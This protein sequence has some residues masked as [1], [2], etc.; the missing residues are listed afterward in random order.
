MR[1]AMILIL[2]LISSVGCRVSPSSR[3]RVVFSEEGR[4][5]DL[6]CRRPPGFDN[7]G[8]LQ[9]SGRPCL[10][11]LRTNRTVLD[12]ERD[13]DRAVLHLH[14]TARG[15]SGRYVCF[16]K[17]SCTDR[18]TVVERVLVLRRVHIS[19]ETSGILCRS[20]FPPRVPIVLLLNGMFYRRGETDDPTSSIFFPFLSGD[21][22][23]RYAYTCAVEI[24]SCLAPS[25]V[26]VVIATESPDGHE[27]TVCV[28]RRE[29]GVV[30]KSQ[31]TLRLQSCADELTTEV[32]IFLERNDVCGRIPPGVQ[33]TYYHFRGASGR[34]HIVRRPPSADVVS[35]NASTIGCRLSTRVSSGTLRLISARNGLRCELRLVDPRGNQRNGVGWHGGW[36][37]DAFVDDDGFHVLTCLR[38]DSSERDE[39]LFCVYT[40]T[41]AYGSCASIPPSGRARPPLH[42]VLVLFVTFVFCGVTVAFVVDYIRTEG[43]P[44]DAMP[45]RVRGGGVDGGG[46]TGSTAIRL[47]EGLGTRCN[48]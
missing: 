19:V 7:W 12:V 44:D 16:L 5:I 33:W 39:D 24:G 27:T 1:I 32:P 2:F 11:E 22:P 20:E 14:D 38:P 21:P 45:R 6:E 47:E 10:S 48:I 36:Q 37:A 25:D 9:W 17:D 3:P 43:I 46:A 30:E 4:K 15:A 8:D 40:T 42:R 13:R 28:D 23:G 35:I 26:S 29:L 18:V 31:A 41:E 34:V